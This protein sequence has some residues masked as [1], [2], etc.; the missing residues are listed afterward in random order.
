MQPIQLLRVDDAAICGYAAESEM[1][2]RSCPRACLQAPR[3]RTPPHRQDSIRWAGGGDFFRAVEVKKWPFRAC[4]VAGSSQTERT[5]FVS[6]W[7][8]YGLKG[9]RWNGLLRASFQDNRT[10]PKEERSH[11]ANL[12]MAASAFRAALGERRTERPHQEE[13]PRDGDWTGGTRRPRRS[14]VRVTSTQHHPRKKLCLLASSPPAST[15][16]LQSDT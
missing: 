16:S 10:R 7:F 6:G 11:A 12:P 8:P 15:L 5:F 13:E 9:Y 2:T 3:S 14:A 1:A 4:F